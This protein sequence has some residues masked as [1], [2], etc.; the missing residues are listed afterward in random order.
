[1]TIDILDNSYQDSFL[2]CYKIRSSSA[3]SNETS[4]RQSLP[5]IKFGCGENTP[6]N[7]S[8]KNKPCENSFNDHKGFTSKFRGKIIFHR[9][10]VDE[11]KK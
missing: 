6:D 7:R 10:L 3:F 4:I 9:K 8:S 11:L 1:M 5:E 2:Y